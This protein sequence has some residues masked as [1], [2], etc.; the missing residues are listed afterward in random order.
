MFIKVKINNIIFNTA[1]KKLKEINLNYQCLKIKVQ[2]RQ[3]M[4]KKSIISIIDNDNNTWKNIILNIESTRHISI[5]SKI[6]DLDTENEINLPK[7]NRNYDFNIVFLHKIREFI[8]LFENILEKLKHKDLEENAKENE[9]HKKFM[10]NKLYELY[11]YK[12]LFKVKLIFIKFLYYFIPYGILL[13]SL[14]ILK[15]SDVDYDAFLNF[16]VGLG[17][18]IFAMPSLLFFNNLIQYLKILSFKKLKI[19]FSKSLLL[20]VSLQIFITLVITTIMIYGFNQLENTKSSN[21]HV[22]HDIFVFFKDM[23][24]STEILID[25]NLSKTYT[26]FNDSKENITILSSNFILIAKIIIGIM[27]TVIILNI[28]NVFIKEYDQFFYEQTIKRYLLPPE[29]LKVLSI[30]FIFIIY[31]TYTYVM[32]SAYPYEKSIE[33]TTITSHMDSNTTQFIAMDNIAKAIE[34]KPSFEDILPFG[35][36]I[37][38]FGTLLSIS[39][40][41]IMA[42][43]FAGLSM[44]MNHPYE[45]GDRVKIENSEILEVQEIGIRNDKF[46]EI[47]SNSIIS[48]PHAKLATSS[49]KNYTH[50]TLDY[51]KELTIYLKGS[52]QSS[53]RDAEKVL[54]VSA[55]IN[56]GVKL[57][58]IDESIVD[59]IKDKNINLD[60]FKEYINAKHSEIEK[61]LNTENHEIIKKINK[62]WEKLT[63]INKNQKDENNKHY[64]FKNIFI[65][66]LPIDNNLSK[67]TKDKTIL[68]IKKVL[69][70]IIA[71]V[72]EYQK[73]IEDDFSPLSDK[74][75]I[76]RK[77]MVFDEKDNQIKEFSDILIDISFYY[78]MLANRL[79]ELKEKQTTLTQKRKID[80][81]M[82]QLLNV[83]RVSSIQEVNDGETYWKT[84]L[85]VTLELSEQGDETLHHINMYIDKI[86]DKFLKDKNNKLRYID[87]KRKSNN[88]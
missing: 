72:S 37:A 6:K 84:T 22:F 69:I 39:S 26:F 81:A 70:A 80:K 29:L 20:D 55:F 79:W 73:K 33:S 11:L 49:I 59:E 28:M 58:K 78:Y 17:I 8:I 32:V 52:Q 25:G 67:D 51:R 13:L 43:Y 44:K 66:K 71:S 16:F 30:F 47:S 62:T 46:Y 57:P 40:R 85:F 31:L 35:L 53:P 24:F 1:D 83:P 74:N 87:K 86:W 45:E 5:L 63:E 65:D 64:F 38:L 50:P 12:Y 14:N 9:K 82:T 19:S 61:D 2:I 75:G 15:S 27:G 34:E 48:I 42:N 36:F 54:L 76:R 10:E 4:N 23:I 18:L 41:D 77:Y 88:F 56:T 7:Y 60:I 68:S 3:E 21:P